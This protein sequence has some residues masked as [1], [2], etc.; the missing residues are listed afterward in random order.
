MHTIEH[1][2]PTYK[3]K[4]GTGLAF[5]DGRAETDDPKLVRYFQQA[6][7][8]VNGQ[9][10]NAS[11]AGERVTVADPRNHPARLIGPPLRDAAVDP[12]EGDNAPAGA[13]KGNPHDGAQVAA[14][15]AAARAIR[16]REAIEAEAARLAEEEALEKAARAEARK[17][18]AGTAQTPAKAV[19][20]AKPAAK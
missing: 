2:N 17:A 20:G 8:T 9:Q 12:R 16:D 18:E 4:H 10:H 6:G 11:P 13:G 14:N 1:P 15:G 5:V 7:F 3:G 19:K